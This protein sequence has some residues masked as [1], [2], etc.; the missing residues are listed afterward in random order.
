MQ[1]IRSPVISQIT[2]DR[3]HASHTHTRDL[4]DQP[5]VLHRMIRDRG[6]SAEGPIWRSSDTQRAISRS[7]PGRRGV[8]KLA[9]RRKGDE[10]AYR[11]GAV[12]HRACRAEFRAGTQGLTFLL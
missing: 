11:S 2:L 6:F 8:E 4:V 10:A 1:I 3:L 9:R 12:L 7:I 5:S